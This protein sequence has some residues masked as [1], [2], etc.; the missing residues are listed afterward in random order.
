MRI[1]GIFKTGP[2]GMIK[3]HGISVRPK[4]MALDEA[5][6]T[7]DDVEIG[8]VL[9]TCVLDDGSVLMEAE[10]KDEFRVLLED[11]MREDSPI[12]K[13]LREEPNLDLVSCRWCGKK[14]HQMEWRW[15]RWGAH[16]FC[17]NSCWEA[18]QREYE[19][20]SRGLV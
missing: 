6:I 11:K 2:D 18:A 16:G 7:H 3:L 8:R 5:P 9:K 15:F 4:D 19:N 1:R 20:G 14:G 10:I 17:S 12:L 13:A